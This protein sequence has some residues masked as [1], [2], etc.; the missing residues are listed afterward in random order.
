[1]AFVGNVQPMCKSLSHQTYL[2]LTLLI[3][4]DRNT[5]LHMKHRQFL[6]SEITYEI[7]R[8][9]GP[10][11]M[12]ERFTHFSPPVCLLSS[13]PLPEAHLQRPSIP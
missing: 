6:K 13:S 8:S 7:P 4:N 3:A 1:M 9:S 12:K 5:A 2:S 10:K 11:P